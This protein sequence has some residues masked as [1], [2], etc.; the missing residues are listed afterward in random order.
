MLTLNQVIP[1]TESGSGV[2]SSTPSSS[3]S[4]I[5]PFTPSRL[6][7]EKYLKIVGISFD[8]A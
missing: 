5:V 6:F 8:I 2:V 3:S 4:L 1:M 7:P